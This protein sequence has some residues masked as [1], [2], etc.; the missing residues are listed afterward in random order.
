MISWVEW[1]KGGEEAKSPEALSIND[2]WERYSAQRSVTRFPESRRRSA[3]AAISR[4]GREDLVVVHSEGEG[5]WVASFE[6]TR[7]APN[8]MRPALNAFV[9]LIYLDWVV[10]SEGL[11]VL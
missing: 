4:Y 3:S 11:D 6:E 9:I 7:R 5:L 1:A 2:S 8:M 10:Y